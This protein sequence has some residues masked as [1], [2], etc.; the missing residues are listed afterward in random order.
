MTIIAGKIELS[1]GLKS[2]LNDN[3]L[4]TF[5]NISNDKA[6]A[7]PKNIFLPNDA[8]LEDPKMNNIATKII[9]IRVIG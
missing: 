8:S 6:I 3:A 7:T 1:K 9:A 2:K 5:N 4:L